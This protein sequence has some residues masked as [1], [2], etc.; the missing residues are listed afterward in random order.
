MLQCDMCNSVFDEPEIETV[1]AKQYYGVG[2]SF[3]HHNMIQI[4]VCPK[5]N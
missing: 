5:K 3:N 4:E 2:G 1:S